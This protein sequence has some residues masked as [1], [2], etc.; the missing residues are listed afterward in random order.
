MHPVATRKERRMASTREV[1][2]FRPTQ[3]GSFVTASAMRS[4]NGCLSSARVSLGWI[5]ATATAA[6]GFC[7]RP[8]MVIS[9]TCSTPAC[10]F[11]CR[12]AAASCAYAGAAERARR[13]NVTPNTVGFMAALSLLHED[14]GMSRTIP[15]D[16]D[17]AGAGG[18]VDPPQDGGG[19]AG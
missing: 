18:L 5:L 9:P 8:T 3:K 4:R 17:V 11:V 19:G 6:M 14:Y 1:P 16:E 13:A 15:L 7:T 10:C 12:A 2:W